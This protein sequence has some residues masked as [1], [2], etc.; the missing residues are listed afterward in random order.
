M[1]F[2]KNSVIKI[3]ETGESI[4]VN[5]QPLTQKDKL[6]SFGD[7]VNGTEIMFI[8]G[9]WDEGTIFYL[10][11]V[12]YRIEKSLKYSGFSKH[13]ECCIIKNKKRFG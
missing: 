12:E 8:D 13:S 11:D 9:I 7:G 10:N 5:V 1:V 4:D 2:F 3:K 6:D